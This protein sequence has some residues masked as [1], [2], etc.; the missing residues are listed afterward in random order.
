MCKS[1]HEE[2]LEL[3]SEASVVD[4]DPQ[5]S[6]NAFL[7]LEGGKEELRTQQQ[8]CFQFE[9]TSLGEFQTCKTLN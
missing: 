9:K 1:F 7:L 4:G 3:P 2:S 5:E 6:W 8:F